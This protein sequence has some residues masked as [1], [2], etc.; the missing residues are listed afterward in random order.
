MTDDQWLG[1]VP[2]WHPEGG[3]DGAKDNP[4]DRIN[5]FKQEGYNTFVFWHH[6]LKDLELLKNRIIEF[7]KGDFVWQMING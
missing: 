7:N 1:L 6:E 2:I 3:K 5:F 4:Q